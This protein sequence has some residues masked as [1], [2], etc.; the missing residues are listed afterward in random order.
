MRVFDSHLLQTPMQKC[1]HCDEPIAL[2]SYNEVTDPAHQRPFC[3]QGCLTVYEVLQ[4]KGLEDYYQIKQQAGIYKRRSPVEIQQAKYQYM[5]D[6]EFLL[7][8]SYRN[9]DGLVSMEFYLEG[10]HC[11]ACLW[12]IE[13]LPLLVPNVIHA[14]LDIEKSVVTVCLSSQ[15]KFSLVAQ[16]LNQ[17]G[18]KPHALKKNQDT[19]NYKNKEERQFLLRTGIA[20]AG[21]SNIM[22]YSV[23]IYA[24]AGEMY[25]QIFNAL[26]IF[27]AIPVLSYSAFPFYKN[28]WQSFKNKALSIDVPIA[29]SLLVGSAFGVYNLLV[30]VHE[31]YFDSLTTLVFLLLLSRYF[32]KK[33]QDKALSSKDLHFFYQEE[34]VQRGIGGSFKSFE[35]IHPKFISV[36]DIVK[37]NAGHFFPA[38]GTIVGGQSYANMALL[39]GESLPVAM[40][41]GDMVFAGTQNI[42]D[43][44][45]FK[46][47]KVKNGTKLG[48]ILKGVEVGWSK[49]AAIVNLTDKISKY[50]VTAVF[51][52]SVGVFIQHA[53]SGDIKT[54]I[55]LSLTL[56]IVTCPCALALAVPLTFIKA[57]N[58]AA[59][60]GVIIKN[61]SVIQKLTEVQNVLIDKTGTITF[62]KMS[63]KNFR[64]IAANM[65]HVS[66]HDIILTLES[67]SQHP[68]GRA[69]T[70]YS[71]CH[72]A[73]IQPCSQ[74]KEVLGSGVQGNIHGHLYKINREGL[75]QEGELIA[76][77]DLVDVVRD[78]SKLAIQKLRSLGLGIKMISG[79]QAE[80]VH[81]VAN[82][83]GINPDETKS[84]MSPEEKSQV[85]KDTRKPMVI[86]DGANDAIAFSNAHV[87]V[88]VLGAMDM[89]LMVADIYL[90]VPGLSHIEKVITL[91]RETLKVIYRNL[92]LS[93]IYNLISV[94]LVFQGLISPLMA[95]VIMPV[96]SLT[97]LLSTIYGTR[98]MRKIWK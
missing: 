10:I 97:V 44:I 13:K 51:V 28:A 98:K 1:F 68:A 26:T 16:E 73:K 74:W 53:W 79:D 36:G 9:F 8:F 42:S 21:A 89:A 93:L 52:L 48:Q 5:D 91:G 50:F 39:T 37:V 22:I 88:A 76:T 94:V 66:V 56:L 92:V 40:R 34:S 84:A 18:Y 41:T 49:R 61:E 31:N 14:K 24:G 33:I 46:V 57:L 71:M 20:A 32:L 17:L 87:G 64:L 67:A 82:D 45:I 55:E 63:I 60:H 54:A 86:G 43:E 62:G 70:N 81:S 72:G 11:L 75:W 38:D 15:G 27:F 25:G 85:V 65:S 2:V 19:F 35:E 80:I 77:Y 47:D 29:I 90:I 23:S 12:L 58:T 69:L 83:V 59:D 96:S 4:T 6:E 78:D 95:A 7:E 30:G 3:C